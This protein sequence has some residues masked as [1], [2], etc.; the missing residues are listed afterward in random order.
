[1]Y[2][3]SI[4]S[5]FDPF[6]LALAVWRIVSQ[7]VRGNGGIPP[8][9]R[10]KIEREEKLGNLGWLVANRLLFWEKACLESREDLKMG[11]RTSCFWVLANFRSLLRGAAASSWENR[12]RPVEQRTKL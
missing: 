11:G 3:T 8:F 12:L 4:G 9:G 1:V 6:D 2:T 10:G 7:L 5:S